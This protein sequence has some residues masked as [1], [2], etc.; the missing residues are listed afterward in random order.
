MP[1]LRLAYA[2][3]FLIALIAVFVLWSQVGGQSHLDLMP[4]Y[5]K[6]GLGAGAALAAVKATAAAVAREQPWN[7]GTLKWFGILLALL[8]GCGLAS[9]YYHVYGETDEEQ[10]QPDVSQ[11]SRPP[12]P[13]PWLT[14]LPTTRPVARAGNSPQPGEVEQPPVTGFVSIA[15]SR[16]SHAFARLSR[17]SMGQPTPSTCNPRPR[18]TSMATIRR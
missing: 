5:L 7:S 2:T 13:S 1:L 16:R 11:W 4:W 15:G 14:G 17:Y 18:S 9:Y 12:S 10:D 8:A 6:L 3:Q